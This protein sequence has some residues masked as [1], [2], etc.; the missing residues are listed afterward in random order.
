MKKLSRSADKTSA[1]DEATADCIDMIRCRFHD[2]G[3]T[4]TWMLIIALCSLVN[5]V[6]GYDVIA[7]A[8]LVGM[9]IGLILLAGLSDRFGRR[10]VLMPFVLLML[11]F[12]SRQLSL[13]FTEMEW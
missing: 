3:F 1:F 5:C 7:I 13:K 9:I 12:V 11:V 8:I 10:T 2:R 6:D 4:V